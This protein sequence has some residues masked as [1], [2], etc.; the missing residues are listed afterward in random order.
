MKTSDAVKQLGLYASA[1]CNAD[2][3]FD[4]RDTLTRCPACQSLCFWE[5]VEPVV[6][7][8]ELENSADEQSLRAA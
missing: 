1:C 5:F 4:R 2:A 7:W 6:S 8:M 3:L